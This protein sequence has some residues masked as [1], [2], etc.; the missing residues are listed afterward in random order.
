MDE[1]RMQRMEEAQAFTE[2]EVEGLSEALRDAFARIEGLTRRIAALE[3]RVEAV[4]MG[5]EEGEEGS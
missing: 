3:G 5:D 2:R 4:E 1:E